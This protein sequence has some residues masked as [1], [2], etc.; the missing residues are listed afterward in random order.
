MSEYNEFVTAI[1]KIFS[2]ITTM[3]NKYTDKDNIEYLEKLISYQQ[4]VIEI[5]KTLPQTTK[6]VEELGQ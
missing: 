4:Q 6:S 2:S 3:K 1:N 5:S